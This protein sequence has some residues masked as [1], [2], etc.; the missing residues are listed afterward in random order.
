MKQTRDSIADV[1]GQPAFYTND[2]LVRVD[3]QKIEEPEKQIS[4]LLTQINQAAL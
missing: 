2:S 1:W 3:E 4:W